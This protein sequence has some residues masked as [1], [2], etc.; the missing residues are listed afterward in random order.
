MR[1]IVL[2]C[3]AASVPTIADDEKDCPLKREGHLDWCP[4]QVDIQRCFEV[5]RTSDTHWVR[6]LQAMNPADSVPDPLPGR[7]D[8]A[9]VLALVR[10]AAL[11][12]GDDRK[13]MMM[14]S[15]RDPKPLSPPNE[16]TGRYASTY[17][18][19]S[20]EIHHANEKEYRVV[21]YYTHHSKFRNQLLVEL[22][23]VE[24]RSVLSLNPLH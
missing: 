15:F 17:H 9:E 20:V 10:E 7:C 12:R 14:G 24:K 19:C 4:S 2:L 23:R 8:S 16:G 6:C 3:V 1:F 18:S 11:M 13:I 22:D 5:Y 21:F